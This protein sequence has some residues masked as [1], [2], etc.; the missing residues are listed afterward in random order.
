M[1]RFGLKPGSV[2]GGFLASGLRAPVVEGVFVVGDA[3]GHC[4]PLTGEGIRTAVLGGFRC[5]ELIEGVLSGELTPGEAATAYRAFVEG[6]RRT[7][8]RLLWG[9]LALLALPS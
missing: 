9:N 8:R 5:G 1:G 3:S 7:F 2:H 4:L 6:S